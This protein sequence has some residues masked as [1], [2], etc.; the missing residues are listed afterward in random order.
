MMSENYAAPNDRIMKTSDEDVLGKAITGEALSRHERKHEGNCVPDSINT[1]DPARIESEVVELLRQHTAALARYA[2]TITRDR[3]VV[4]DGIQE[5]FLRYF[6]TRAGGQQVENPRAWLFKVLRNYILDCKRKD[7][8]IST[9]DLESAGRILDS[10]QDVEAGYQQHE[11]FQF[12]LSTLSPREQEC[13]QL[14]LEGF[15]YEE[16]AQILRIRSGTVAALLARG[17]RKMRESG[18]LKRGS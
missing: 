16:I 2:A 1:D 18:F 10:R 14:R 3:T 7:R 17:F 9:V 6:T 13:I 4:Q 15:G 8:S 5:T 11:N 12:A